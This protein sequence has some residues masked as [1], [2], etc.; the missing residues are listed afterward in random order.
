MGKGGY[1][2]ATAVFAG[3][4][5]L[6]LLAGLLL[7]TGAGLALIAVAL[8]ATSIVFARSEQAMAP[9]QSSAVFQ[10]VGGGGGPNASPAAPAPAAPA[11]APP[12]A[13]KETEAHPS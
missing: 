13:E 10:S 1:S 4:L 5:V 7:G 2:T 3:G 6:A 8:L 9:G 12:E 11:P